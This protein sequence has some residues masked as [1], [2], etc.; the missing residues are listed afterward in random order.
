MQSSTEGT[1]SFSWYLKALQEKE[2][3]LK[4]SPDP[5]PEAAQE[6][7]FLR[8]IKVFSPTVERLGDFGK[9]ELGMPLMTVAEVLYKLASDKQIELVEASAASNDQNEKIVRITDKG[10]KRLE[11]GE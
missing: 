4:Q 2:Q 8:F 5:I 10:S 9:T 1:E 7:S 6:I 3:Q 11:T